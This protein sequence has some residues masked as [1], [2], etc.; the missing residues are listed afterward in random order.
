MIFYHVAAETV[1]AGRVLY[2]RRDYMALLFG[3]QITDEE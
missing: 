1:Y 3:S 2:G